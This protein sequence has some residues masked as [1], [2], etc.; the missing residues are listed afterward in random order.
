MIDYTNGT[1]FD[2]VIE[3]NSPTSSDKREVL[4]DCGMLATWIVVSD[5]D[6]SLQLD[7]PEA[8]YMS[9]KRISLVMATSTVDSLHKNGM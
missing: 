3:I 6:T 7:P 2:L 8:K 5:D 9:S 1:G 4:H